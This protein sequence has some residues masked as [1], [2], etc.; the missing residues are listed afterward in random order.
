M[1]YGDSMHM[2]SGVLMASKIPKTRA[3]HTMTEAGFRGF[4]RSMLRRGSTRWKP[5][6][7]VKRKARHHEKLPNDRGRLVFHSVCAS[8]GSLVPETTTAVDHINPVVDPNV[9]FVSWDE[10]INRLFCEEDNLQ[11]LCKPCHDAKTAE[12]KAIDKARKSHE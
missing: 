4:I 12:E 1:R 6:Y 7:E 2:G 9:G 10:F 3:S 11:V 5:K 8:C